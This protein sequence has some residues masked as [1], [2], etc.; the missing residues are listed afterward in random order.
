MCRGSRRGLTRSSGDLK[1]KAL[2]PGGP[3][4]GPSAIL[5]PP[6]HASHLRTARCDWRLIHDADGLPGRGVHTAS[7]DGAS[8]RTRGNP[9]PPANTEIVWTPIPRTAGP[10]RRCSGRECMEVPGSSST[11]T[12]NRSSAE[13][14]LD[15]TFSDPTSV[16]VEFRGR[17]PPD[18][19]QPANPT[20]HDHRGP[21]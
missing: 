10:G 6:P 21:P 2:P 20:P 16:S 14:A 18:Q 13:P 5:R 15:V 19:F 7:R 8:R 3:H 17:T 1:G 11:L 12:L 4:R 9:G